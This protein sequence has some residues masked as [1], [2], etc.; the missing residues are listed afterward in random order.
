MDELRTKI[1]NR[2][3]ACERRMRAMPLEVDADY[4]EL[5]RGAAHWAKLQGL[6]A[7][8]HGVIR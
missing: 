1:R 4:E 6:L 3:R 5:A 2:I 7:M 8:T